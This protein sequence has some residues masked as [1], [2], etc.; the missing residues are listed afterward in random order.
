MARRSGRRTPALSPL[1]ALIALAVIAPSS[2]LAAPAPDSPATASGA[3][4]GAKRTPRPP[5]LAPDF[6][7][8]GRYIVRDLGV[9]VPFRWRGRDG[10]SQMIAGGRKYPI[11]F[12]NLIYNN[13]LY[14]LTYRWPNIAPGSGAL[15]CMKLGGFFSRQTFNNFLKGSRFVGREILRGGPRRF[16]NHWR[17][18]VVLPPLPP[19]AFVR[20]PFVLGDFYVGRRNRSRFWQVLH[21]GVQN[22]FD[23]ELDEWMRMQRFVPGRPG[24]VT[25]P[26]GCPAPNP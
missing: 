26:E 5:R 22:L 6:Q 10:N 21:F 4:S 8:S 13:T 14:T 25:L 2:G 19:G 1:A 18:G 7:A 24:K 16:V 23:P 3:A 17:V 15:N 12:T 11:W 20:L 9:N